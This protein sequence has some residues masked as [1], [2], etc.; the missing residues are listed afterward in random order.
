MHISASVCPFTG[1][2]A[3]PR[4]KITP[5][6]TCLIAV[7][8]ASGRGVWRHVRPGP[9]GIQGVGHHG[10]NGG[11]QPAMPHLGASR[12]TQHKGTNR[13]KGTKLHKGTSRQSTM[14]RRLGVAIHG[15]LATARNRLTS[16]TASKYPTMLPLWHSRCGLDSGSPQQQQLQGGTGTGGCTARTSCCISTLTKLKAEGWRALEAQAPRH[17]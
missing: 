10:I 13:H 12:S 3:L 16:K 1:K 4:H 2:G 15:W 8:A 11:H 5:C 6:V 14:R 7:V 17:R 9:Q